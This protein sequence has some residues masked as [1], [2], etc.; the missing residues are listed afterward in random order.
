MSTL[1]SRFLEAYTGSPEVAREII[2]ILKSETPSRVVAIR[3]AIRLRDYD[4]AARVLHKTVNS[5][6][7]VDLDARLVPQLQS[8]EHDLREHNPQALDRAEQVCAR[9]DELVESLEEYS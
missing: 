8:L 2:Q 4:S 5:L 9:L 6:G 7:P 1:I 3:T